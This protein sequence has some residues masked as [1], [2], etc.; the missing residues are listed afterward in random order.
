[1]ADA[2][3]GV[4]AGANIPALA[5]NPKLADKDFVV[6]IILHGRGGMPW[7]N[8]ILTHEQI[9][10]VSTYVRGQFNDY[11]DP[12]TEAD[13]NSVAARITPSPQSCATC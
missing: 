3:G 8:E 4:G 7:L 6:G 11:H 5:H 13:V 10:A 1:M 12:V 9:A 2:K